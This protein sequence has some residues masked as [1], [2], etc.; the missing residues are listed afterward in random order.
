MTMRLLYAPLTCA[1]LGLLAGCGNDLSAG[2]PGPKQAA[3]DV[4]VPGITAGSSF[5]F[6][7]GT[8]VNGKYYLTDR[9]N[10][11][12]DVVDVLSLALTQIKGAGTNAF[13]GCAPTANC[14][15]ANNGLSGPDGINFISAT[16]MFY[17]GD[18][19]TVRVVDPVAAT[20]VN[21]IA[22]ANRCPTM[23]E[24]KIVI[25]TISA[26]NTVLVIRLA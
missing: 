11:A 2:T 26:G 24:R 9:N 22:T 8:V 16:G 17:V 21:S 6:D 5:S 15:G 23:A 19:N 12:V 3:A 18:I 13:A 14:V 10:K 1:A 4:P 7:L 20:V 25:G